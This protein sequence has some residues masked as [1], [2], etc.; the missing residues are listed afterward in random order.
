M[1]AGPLPEDELRWQE[2][3]LLH[4]L[5]RSDVMTQCESGCPSCS[6]M[7]DK[8]PTG[9]SS[10]LPAFDPLSRFDVFPRDLRAVIH[11][12]GSI[13]PGLVHLVAAVRAYESMSPPQVG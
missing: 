8:F 9:C 6:R 11:R 12:A 10:G 13:A 7:A 3:H 2:Q 4:V 5:V 1:S